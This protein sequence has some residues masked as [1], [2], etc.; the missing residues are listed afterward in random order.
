MKQ[1]AVIGLGNMG[2]AMFA[3]AQQKMEAEN[4]IVYDANP[5]KV[6]YVTKQFQ[7]TAANNNAECV[8]DSKFVVLAVKPQY[9]QDV[10]DEI[11]DEITD[12]QIVISLAPGISIDNLKER[13]GKNVRVIRIMPNTSALILE[14]MTAGCYSKDEFTVEEKQLARE[15]FESFG[16]FEEV[17]EAMMSAVVSISGSSPAYAYMFIEALADGG[18]KYG[19]PREKAYKFA[20]QALLGS[21]KMLLDTKEHPGKLKDNV[22]SPGG[23]TIAAVAALEEQGFRNAV[24]KAVDACYE[25]S[26][27]IK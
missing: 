24:L 27:G 25:K 26:E 8:K 2:Y 13:F 12:S 14:S 15:F 5:E 17:E 9:Y 22:C 3:G 20:A 19:L 10:I 7:V 6:E 16:E 18:V 21:A 11:K 4:F 1:F 23:T